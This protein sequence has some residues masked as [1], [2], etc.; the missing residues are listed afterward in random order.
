MAK[1]P[2]GWTPR[3]NK[4]HSRSYALSEAQVSKHLRPS[5]RRDRHLP[6]RKMLLHAWFA[7]LMPNNMLALL[8]AALLQYAG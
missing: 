8:F 7:Y 2:G 3:W 4:M 5:Q 6:G 1:G